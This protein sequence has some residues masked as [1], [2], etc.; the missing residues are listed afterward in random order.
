MKLLMQCAQGMSLMPLTEEQLE[1]VQVGAALVPLAML[2]SSD[3][4]EPK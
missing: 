3:D 4:E 2:L 1:S